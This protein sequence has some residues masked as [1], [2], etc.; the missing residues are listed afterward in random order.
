MLTFLRLFRRLPAIED[1]FSYIEAVSSLLIAIIRLTEPM[2]L[3]T[4]KEHARRLF[5][6]S[7]KSF[8][9]NYD[10]IMED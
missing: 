6:K 2:I 1:L 7:K 9:E 8:E 10:S 3:F 5:C 4:L